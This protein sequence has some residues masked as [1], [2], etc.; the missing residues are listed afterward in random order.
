MMSN[1]FP[2][3]CCGLFCNSL[4]LIKLIA[5]FSIFVKSYILFMRCLFQSY[6]LIPIFLPWIF[7]FIHQFIRALYIRGRSLMLSGSVSWIHWLQ[8]VIKYFKLL[9]T[10]W[11]CLLIDYWDKKSPIMSRKKYLG[12]D[13]MK[14]IQKRYKCTKTSVATTSS[15]RIHLME[16]SRVS[17]FLVIRIFFSWIQ[18]FLCLFLRKSLCNFQMYSDL[19]TNRYKLYFCFVHNLAPGLLVLINVN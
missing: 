9:W 7:F 13:K 16:V 10:S 1:H 11:P 3:C 17:L 12:T 19:W 15:F 14:R 4:V 18:T 6:S 5:P 2:K 8:V